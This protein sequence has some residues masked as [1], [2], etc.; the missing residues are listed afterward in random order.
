MEKVFKG[1]VF[2]QKY[3]I[4]S[5]GLQKKDEMVIQWLII[6]SELFQCLLWNELVYL[7]NDKLY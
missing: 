5:L 1:H 4:L 6:F 7:F 3:W 2:S